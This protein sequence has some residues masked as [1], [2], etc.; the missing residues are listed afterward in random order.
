M[1]ASPEASFLRERSGKA[2]KETA[3]RGKA[4]E[5]HA[6]GSKSKTFRN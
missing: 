4:V 3:C 6:S 1:G 2:S 5:R